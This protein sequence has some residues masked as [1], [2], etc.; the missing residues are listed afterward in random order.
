MKKILITLATVA[1][2]SGTVFNPTF[3][4]T[5]AKATM[6][7]DHNLRTTNESAGDICKKL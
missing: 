6:N 3:Y 5:R 4:S 2:T 1:L 7:P